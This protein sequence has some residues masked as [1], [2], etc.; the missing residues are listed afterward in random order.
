MLVNL[1]PE[2]AVRMLFIDTRGTLLSKFDQLV[3]YP[4]IL[5]GPFLGRKETLIGFEIVA[6][7]IE[8]RINESYGINREKDVI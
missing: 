6:K 1:A 5:S 8:F 3:T 4:D 2:Y 7:E